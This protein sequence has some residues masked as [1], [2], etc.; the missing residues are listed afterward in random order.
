LALTGPHAV[1]DARYVTIGGI[2]QWIS[3]RGEDRANP[4]ILI[5][6]GGPGA[7]LSSSAAAFRGW[8]H[9]F[10]IVQWDQ[11]GGGLTFAAGARLTNDLPM[12]RMVDD[13][14]A[15]A[16]YVRHRLGVKRMILLGHSWG[17]FLGVEMVKARPDLFSAYVGTGQLMDAASEIN[18][19]YDTTL[20]R[21]R[22]AHRE[23]DVKAL[24][25]IGRPPYSSNA[26]LSTL[27]LTRKHY[28][29][30]VDARYMG[31]GEESGLRQTLTSPDLTLGQAV[32]SIQGMLETAGTLDIYPPLAHADLRALGCN[33][34]IPVFIIEGDDDRFTYTALA[35]LYYDCIVAPHKAYTTIAGG[36]FAMLTNAAA[37]HD[38]LV[39]L[40]RPLAVQAIERQ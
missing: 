27:L 37:F 5:V 17:S 29:D 30:P 21:A 36:H 25:A 4:V 39:R 16:D 23:E 34:P 3:I 1:H 11:R 8:E 35:R 31:L 9:D 33:I 22:A 2:P 10:T 13:G 18:L 38:A 20:A 6:H 12:Q 32:A 28:I 40:V 19:A 24:Q 15:A 14:I 7:S 26:D